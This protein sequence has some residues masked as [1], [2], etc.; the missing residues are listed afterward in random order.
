MHQHGT[1]S[2]PTP[3]W[4]GTGACPPPDT[5]PETQPPE[6]PRRRRKRENPD[7]E[8]APLPTDPVATMLERARRGDVGVLTE[9]RAHLREHPEL[10]ET[11]GDLARIAKAHW[12]VKIAGND[13]LV[14]EAIGQETLSMAESLGWHSMDTLGQL[15]IDQIL[16]THIQLSYYD[17]LTASPQAPS[18]HRELK[19]LCDLQDATHRR[20][21]YAIKA[22]SEYRQSKSHSGMDAHHA[23]EQAIRRRSETSAAPQKAPV[24]PT[25]A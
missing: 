2:I 8:G 16:V 14:A 3:S 9:L 24:T 25:V 21:Q 22:L 15:L 1:P 13:V 11:H 7:T 4:V 12:I 5:V 20:L 6:S 10:I 18:N 19:L 23:G 17:K